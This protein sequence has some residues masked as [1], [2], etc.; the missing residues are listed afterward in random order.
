MEEAI[1]ALEREFKKITNDLDY[2]THC[3]TAD[4]KVSSTEVPD[5]FKLIKRLHDMESR[6]LK[7]R[8]KAEV[9]VKKRRQV[10]ESVSEKLIQNNEMISKMFMTTKYEND[11]LT[12]DMDEVRHSLQV[13]LKGCSDSTLSY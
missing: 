7:S 12:D 13:S 10:L 9:V 1:T 4:S 5:I 6:I 2:C 3:F 11:Q 8:Q